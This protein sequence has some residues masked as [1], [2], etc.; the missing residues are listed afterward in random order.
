MLTGLCLVYLAFYSG[1]VID[2]PGIF[3]PST[4]DHYNFID[5]NEILMWV[6]N[7]GDGSHD[8]VSGFS[9]F[10]WPGG[11]FAKKKAVSREGL[12]W[13]CIADGDTLV[14]GNNH[15][16]GLQAGKILSSGAVD[17]PQNPRYRVYK[18]LRNWESLP[19]GQE[20][21]IYQ[22]DY[23]EWPVED[24]A[25]WVDTDHNG[26][27][28]RGIDQP[29]FAG[30]QVLWYVANDLDSS[31]AVTLSGMTGLEIQTTVYGFNTVHFLKDVVFK[32]YLIIN[33]SNSHLDEMYIGYWS[34]DDLGDPDDDFCGCDT[35]LNLGYTYNKDNQD[36]SGSKHTYGT[37]PPAVGH[38][39]VQ[40]PVVS[41]LETDSAKFLNRW[42]KGFRNLSM[43]AFLIFYFSWWSDPYPPPKPHCTEIYHYLKGLAWNGNTLL[44]PH[45]SRP[46]T[47][48]VPGDPVTGEG[49]YEGEGWPET[50]YWFLGDR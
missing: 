21:D 37:S 41:S 18:L 34:D 26:I 45:T 44:D 32:K 31:R 43:S 14:N 20:R 48:F 22:R 3:K 28:T 27:F 19:P 30:D 12:M 15:Y 23:N 17:D 11:K 5:V 9:G 38:M 35:M 6:G 42:Q 24:G 33:K 2:K 8:P 36:G 16:Q 40:G 4:N 46:T 13:G 47:F 10:S 1:R 7:N 49:W 25:P 29:E 39:F 50:Q